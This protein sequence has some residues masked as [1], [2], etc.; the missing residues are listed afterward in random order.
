MKTEN[1]IGSRQVMSP[2]SARSAP[3]SGRCCRNPSFPR[4]WHFI[5]GE[6]SQVQSLSFQSWALKDELYCKYIDER[7][8]KAKFAAFRKSNVHSV[9]Y[10]N[11]VYFFGYTMCYVYVQDNKCIS[12]TEHTSC[13]PRDCET[14]MMIKY[15]IK[16]AHH[17]RNTS[18]AH[19]SWQ[20]VFPFYVSV[21][22]ANKKEL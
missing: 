14:Y 15:N 17:T 6:Q 8:M 4:R 9:T 19:Q 13:Q 7:R 18:R 5:F 2:L 3:W 21:H 20:R 22:K 12:P 16:V 10:S 11:T 1:A